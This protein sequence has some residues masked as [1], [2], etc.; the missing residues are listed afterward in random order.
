MSQA[1]TVEGGRDSSGPRPRSRSTWLKVILLPP[2]EVARLLGREREI[3]VTDI[4][5]AMPWFE[6]EDRIVGFATAYELVSNMSKSVCP[7]LHRRGLDHVHP[8]RP[9]RAKAHRLRIA[10]NL[11][12]TS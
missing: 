12:P 4:N 9:Q 2:I 10:M 1:A 8:K 5:L 3:K 7:G 6:H 11:P